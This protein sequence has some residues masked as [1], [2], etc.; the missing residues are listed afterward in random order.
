MTQY[1][2][3]ATKA[4]HV[5]Q[6]PESVTGSVTTPIFQTSTYA[7][8]EIGKHKGFEY[9]RTQNPTRNVL[10]NQLAALENGNYGICFASGL[11]ATD[12]IVKLFQQGDHII[13]CNDL[14]G[15]TYRIFTKVYG[16]QDSGN[17]IYFSN[18]TH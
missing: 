16:K 9:A 1:K 12:A 11:A 3:F 13:S 2:G 15:G 8:E 10:Q 5:A 17:R 6:E 7:Q 14:Y 4:I 18:S